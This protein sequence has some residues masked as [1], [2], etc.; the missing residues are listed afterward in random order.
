MS[1][2][3]H[4]NDNSVWRKHKDGT[5]NPAIMESIHSL[6]P[7]C[8][9]D[10]NS[11][12]ERSSPNHLSLHGV[13]SIDQFTGHLSITDIN[14]FMLIDGHEYLKVRAILIKLFSFK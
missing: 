2:L 6:P 13:S 8:P 11:N 9:Q 14:S 7:L 10:Q 4:Q 12:A 5:K 1:G 3:D